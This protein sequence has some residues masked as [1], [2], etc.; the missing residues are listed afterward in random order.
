MAHRLTA[1]VLLLALFTACATPPIV[2]LDTG[3]GTPLEYRPLSS[4]P[5]SKAG[6]CAP[7]TPATMRTLE[8]GT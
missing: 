5:P 2:R 1:V 6:W 7:P 4:N 3:L 8:G